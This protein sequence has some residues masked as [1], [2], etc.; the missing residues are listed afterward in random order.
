MSP[1][2]TCQAGHSS[3]LVVTPF[4]SCQCHVPVSQ[5]DQRVGAILRAH[6]CHCHHLPARSAAPHG[7]SFA[8]LSIPIL[9]HPTSPA[10]FLRFWGAEDAQPSPDLC[11]CQLGDRVLSSGPAPAL[12]QTPGVFPLSRKSVPKRLHPGFPDPGL[13]PPS[14]RHSRS[15]CRSAQEVAAPGAAVSGGRGGS[16]LPS[17]SKRSPRALQGN[18][19]VHKSLNAETKPCQ[20]GWPPLSLNSSKDKPGGGRIITGKLKRESSSEIR[21]MGKGRMSSH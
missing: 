20:P 5:C 14:L 13:C 3:G 19:P 2:L 10:G 9:P 8:L 16:S 21:V 1:G 7:H 12:E 15:R 18:P 4:T 11:H 17:S 6:L